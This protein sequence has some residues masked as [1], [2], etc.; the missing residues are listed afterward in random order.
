MRSRR[1]PG[2]ICQPISH[3]GFYHWGRCC[4]GRSAYGEMPAIGLGGR[5]RPPLH[6][7]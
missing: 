6:N 2:L 3:L 7:L 1:L 4:R 5:G